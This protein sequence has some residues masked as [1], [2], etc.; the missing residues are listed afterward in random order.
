MI[1]LENKLIPANFLGIK[2]DNIIHLYSNGIDIQCDMNKITKEAF[3]QYLIKL[4]KILE[5]RNK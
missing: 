2:I 5:S 4:Q 1:L 3:N